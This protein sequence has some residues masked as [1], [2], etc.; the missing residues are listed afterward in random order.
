ML[1]LMLM[2]MMLSLYFGLTVCL[3]LYLKKMKRLTFLL[4]NKAKPIL[5][6]NCYDSK[7]N[8]KTYR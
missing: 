1:M 8:V 2:L 7:R 3:L 4:R 5:K 6:S